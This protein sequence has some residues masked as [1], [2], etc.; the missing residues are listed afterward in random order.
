LAGNYVLVA[1]GYNAGELNG[2]ASLGSPVI[3][4]DDGS[5]SIS[6]KGFGLYGT[7]NTSTFQYPANADGGP[8]NLYIAGTFKFETNTAVVSNHVAYAAST[9]NGSQSFGGEL[10]MEFTVNNPNGITVDQLG[11]FDHQGNGISGTQNGG[12]R[13]AI[14]NKATRTIVPGLDATIVGFADEFV[15]NHRMKNIT[16]VTLLPGTYVVVAKGYNTTELNGNASLGS[17]VMNGD[18]GSGSIGYTGVGLYGSDNPSTFQYPTNGDAGPANIYIAGTFRYNAVVDAGRIVRI[19]A[20]DINGNVA[21]ASAQV[22]V[23]DPNGVCSS[24]FVNARLA[25]VPKETLQDFVEINGLK[26]FPNPTRGIF[27][28]HLKNMKA[29]T[30]I[31]VFNSDGKLVEQKTVGS[32]SITPSVIINFN[33]VNQPSGMYFVKVMSEDGVK[34]T[35]VIIAH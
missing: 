10:G 35:K 16:S 34:V 14:F 22:V 31:D 7:T 5:G 8:P 12:V 26:I 23:R 13:V 24:A 2:N 19:T 29:L 30:V 21:T 20:S 27:S 1:K 28:V 18:N 4:G 3:N 15:S 32:R 17:P 6:F 11:A 33:L 9:S 25:D